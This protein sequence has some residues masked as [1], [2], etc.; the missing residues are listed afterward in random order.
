MFAGSTFFRRSNAM[1]LLKG[2]D[3][4]KIS[5]VKGPC[6]QLRVK[7]NRAERMGPPSGQQHSR[8]S[9]NEYFDGRAHETNRKEKEQK[10]QQRA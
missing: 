9:G 6:L 5:T 10:T 2:L 7:K 4:K 3:D 8:A 1:Q